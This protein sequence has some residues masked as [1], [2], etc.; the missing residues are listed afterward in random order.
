M[1]KAVSGWEFNNVA[2]FHCSYTTTVRRI[3][4]Q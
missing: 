3:A 2:G 1:V 4:V